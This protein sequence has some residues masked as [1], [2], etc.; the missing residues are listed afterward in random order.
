MKRVKVTYSKHHRDYAEGHIFMDKSGACTITL[1]G[2]ASMSQGEL[3]CY[4]KVCAKAIE[5]FLN[6]APLVKNRCLTPSNVKRWH[7]ANNSTQASF[8][9]Q[10]GSVE[11]AANVAEWVNGEG[12]Y[13]QKLRELL[14]NEGMDFDGDI[15]SYTIADATIEG[16]EVW[17]NFQEGNLAAIATIMDYIIQE[18]PP[19]PSPQGFTWANTC[20]KPRIGEFDGGAVV[21]ARGQDWQWLNSGTWLQEQI[22]HIKERPQPGVQTKG[23]AFASPVV[24]TL[25]AVSLTCARANASA[26]APMPCTVQK[27][28][29]FAWFNLT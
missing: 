9:I 2:A 26:A 22:H 6:D 19:V 24:K 16:D 29:C 28:S 15:P 3:D 23:W 25:K 27:N 4:G 21:V 10:C 14:E 18:Y 7:M 13:P 8:M 20:S 17:V 12:N 5:V 11:L 1:T